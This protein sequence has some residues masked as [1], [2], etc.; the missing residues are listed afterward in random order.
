MVREQVLDKAGLLARG[1]LHLLQLPKS[2]YHRYRVLAVRLKEVVAILVGL[3]L[4][5]LRVFRFCQSIAQCAKL[6]VGEGSH[7]RAGRGQAV[8]EGA[9]EQGLLEGPLCVLVG[10]VPY[11]VTDDAKHLVVRHN[12]HQTRVH[13]HATVGAG[14]GVDVGI[15]VHLE[16]QRHT[17]DVS[18]TLGKARQAL[19]V[20]RFRPENFVL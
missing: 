18:K 16:I 7:S 2:L 8:F 20:C 11:L 12:V 9:I 10:D 17:V 3:V 1:L 14:K 13:T 6:A 5:L 4:L 19:A 15:L